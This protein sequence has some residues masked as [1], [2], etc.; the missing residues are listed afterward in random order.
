L[1]LKARNLTSKDLLKIAKC[2]EANVNAFIQEWM[3][4][5][6]TPPSA[7]QSWAQNISESAQSLLSCMGVPYS[8]AWQGLPPDTAFNLL[9][10]CSFGSF[11]VFRKIQKQT[12]LP[13]EI[14]DALEHLG[15]AVFALREIALESARSYKAKEI[16]REK[17]H[18]QDLAMTNLFAEINSLYEFMTGKLPRVSNGDNAFKGVAVTFASDVL[19]LIEPRVG[20]GSSGELNN[21]DALRSGETS[22]KNKLK[23][24]SKNNAAIAGQIQKARKLTP[25]K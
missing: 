12:E 15:A 2:L 4:Q 22:L 19:Q 16:P 10:P 24:L 25:A 1:P 14:N 5:Q 3:L 20:Y 8:D 21:S 13:H 23:E 7:S 9:A 6:K 18:K 11:E 17:R